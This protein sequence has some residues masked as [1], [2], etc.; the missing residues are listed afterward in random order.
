MKDKIIK[1]HNGKDYYMLEEIKYDGKKYVLAAQCDLKED[2]INERELFLMQIRMD[3]DH[4][5]AEEVSDDTLANAVIN[6]F[7]K[8]FQENS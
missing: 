6:E 2:T 7:Q 8:K 5:I 1:L 3:Q 4:L